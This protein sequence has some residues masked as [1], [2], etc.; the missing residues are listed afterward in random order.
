MEII[1]AETVLVSIPFA[2]G[3]IPPWS[4]GGE[5]KFAFDTLLVRLETRSGV[6]GWGEAFSRN[7]D[8]SLKDLIDARVL[9][10]VLGRDASQIVR[11]KFDLEFQLHNFGR[12]GPIVYGISAI[13]IALWDI[14]GKAAGRPL[15]DLLGG[16][17]ADEVEVYASLLRYGNTDDVA[18]ITRQAIER[19][20]RYIKLHEVTLPEIRAA[21]KVAGDDAMI[22]L[23]TNC[24][25]SV[26]E[27]L[28]YDKELEPLG[29]MWLEEPV[30]PPENYRGLAQVRA[31][32]RHR[33]AAGE[34][35]GSVHD[36]MAMID[37]GA[38]DIAQPDVAKTGGVTELLKIAALCEAHGIEYVPHCALFGPGQVATIHL[39]AAHRSVPLLERLYCDFE[40]E[41]YGGATLPK[42]GK[43]T[44]PMAPGLGLDPSPDVVE[45]YRV[46]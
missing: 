39:N 12:I 6:V 16:P 40:A 17:L 35:A 37:A 2:A 3:G 8:T 5:P 11:I 4:F 32:G 44:V 13:D 36:F 29:L 30:W 33:I 9:P 31:T 45:R 14:K 18:K 27:A 34:N 21:V 46:A 41:L 20:Y 43:L 7:E 28:R 38:I 26:A 23:D 25:W 1:K 19:G 42:A 10:L 15:V 24:P 22:M